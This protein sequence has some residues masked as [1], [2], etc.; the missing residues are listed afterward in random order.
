MKKYLVLLALSMAGCR[1]N[2]DIAPDA[3]K[4]DDEFEIETM[5]RNQDCG[6]A[7][8]YVKDAARITQLLGP[9]AYAPVYTALKLDT[10]LWVSK[11]HTLY[12]RVRK[13]GPG[14]A[15]L[16]TAMGPGYQMFVVTSARLKPVAGQ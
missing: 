10:A 15:V 14:E 12:V 13:P 11:N 6:I 9:A 8:V 3:A 2:D 16:C 7:Q 4:A 5:G 1:Q